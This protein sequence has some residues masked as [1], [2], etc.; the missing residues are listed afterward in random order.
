MFALR[1]FPRRAQE[2]LALG[3]KIDLRIPS[4]GLATPLI[5]PA[6]RSPRV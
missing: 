5:E 6:K 1:L 2:A 3:S 4:P